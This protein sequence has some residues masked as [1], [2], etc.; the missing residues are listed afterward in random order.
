MEMV[1]HQGIGVVAQR[2]QLRDFSQHAEENSAIA[3]IEE[4]AHATIS[5]LRDMVRQAGRHESTTSWHLHISL[6]AKSGERVGRPVY[7][8]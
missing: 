2:V 7:C 6:A 5:P 3:G 1:C 8:Q 4:Y